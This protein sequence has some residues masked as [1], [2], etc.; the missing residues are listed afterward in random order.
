MISNKTQLWIVFFVGAAIIITTMVFLLKP[1]KPAKPAKPTN[2]TNNCT[3]G[4]TFISTTGN[5]PIQNGLNTLQLLKGKLIKSITVT[6]TGDFTDLIVQIFQSS[7]A[8]ETQNAINVTDVIP[9]SSIQS[10]TPIDLLPTGKLIKQPY[11]FVYVPQYY[12]SGC[13]LKFN[14]CLE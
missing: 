3:N 10:G 11:L 6:G 5:F 7:S 4:S 8:T 9:T 2:P 12:K 1:A 13:T 14:I